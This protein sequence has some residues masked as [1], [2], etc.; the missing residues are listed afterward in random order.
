VALAAGAAGLAAAFVVVPL[1]TARELDQTFAQATPQVLQLS[2]WDRALPRGASI[3]NDVPP[4]GFQ[5]W[6]DY[7]LHDHPLSALAPLGGFFPHPP[8]GIK[9]DY[10]LTFRPQPR[11]PDAFGRPVEQNAQFELW[12]LRPTDP[13]PDVSR[14]GLIWDVTKITF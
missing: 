13:G 9:A 6:A 5:L 2:S 8:F 12:R 1:G 14:R 3:R 10:A 4:S 7:M 11:P